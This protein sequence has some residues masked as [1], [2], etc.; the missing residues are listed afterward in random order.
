M[1]V[2]KSNGRSALTHS[3]L[4]HAPSLTTE[5]RF[6]VV[7]INYR[8]PLLVKDC[9]ASLEPEIA[10]DRDIVLV[11][12][13]ASGDDSA[14]DLSA[15]IE[16]HGWSDWACVIASTT[17][18]GFSAGN[19][20]GI[21]AVSAK[22]Y[23]LI[24]SDTII[25]TGTLE[26]LW[27]AYETHP[28]VGLIAPRL[29]YLDETPQVST[30]RFPSPMSEFLRGAAT[31]PITRLFN[32]FEVPLDITDE[33]TPCDWASFAAIC[34]RAEVIEAVGLMDEGYFMYFEDVEYCRRAYQSGW[35][36]LHWPEAHIVHLR[37]GSG[38][39][40]KL[41]A[42]RKR[43]PRY[44]YEGRNRYFRQAYGTL[45]SWLANILWL[46][47]LPISLFRQLLKPRESTLCEHEWRD[48]WIGSL[49]T[50]DRAIVTPAER[51]TA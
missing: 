22:A 18:G 42:E 33:P 21:Q 49:R 51:P 10:K 23:L 35:S 48:V 14:Q 5:R 50:G 46:S 37:G 7:I 39:V 2:E 17:N 9:L 19:N 36:V 41:S 3:V 47:G 38:P 15:D 30:F 40:K 13:N 43:R 26:A 8:T 32:G 24:N 31:G 4:G 25:R 45:G 44:Y 34:I 1:P 12:D 29:E 20:L 11:V 27:K 6:A 28:E 16:A